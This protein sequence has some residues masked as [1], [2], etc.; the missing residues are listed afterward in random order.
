MITL[1]RPDLGVPSGGTTYDLRLLREWSG[2]A[3]DVALPGSWPFPSDADRARFALALAEASGSVVVDGL[4]GAACPDEIEVAVARGVRVVLITHL[5]LDADV[6]LPDGVRMRLHDTEQRALN[7]AS[8][9]VVPSHHAL[10]A[11]ESGF[12]VTRPVVVAEPGV[13]PAPLAL[14]SEPPQLLILGALTPN[15]NHAVV[16]DALIRV[17]AGLPWRLVIAGPGETSTLDQRVALLNAGGVGSVGSQSS[18]GAD[19]GPRERSDRTPTGRVTFAGREGNEA[20]AVTE[21]ARTEQ[22]QEAPG[23]PTDRVTV[24][25]AVTGRRLDDLWHATDLLLMPSL[26]ETY[27]LVVTEALARGIPAFVS[28]DTGAAEALA[29][30]PLDQDASDLDAAEPDDLAGRLLDPRDPEAWASALVRWLSDP[31]ERAGVRRLAVDNRTSLN[32][33]SETAAVIARAALG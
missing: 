28:R 6:T 23:T 22:A 21:L 2:S 29:G 7:V 24:T 15:K 33:W 5:P 12:R 25:G 20:A 9:V 30:R 10:R 19:E 32:P 14:G 3:V 1:I 13:D 4:V 27:G 11:L 18:H 26:V 16:L 31:I 17:P 8:V